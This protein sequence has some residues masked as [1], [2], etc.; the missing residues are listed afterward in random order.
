[1]LLKT[2][3]KD[4]PA[5]DLGDNRDVLRSSMSCKKTSKGD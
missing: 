1:M 4:I 5:V 3:K 2:H